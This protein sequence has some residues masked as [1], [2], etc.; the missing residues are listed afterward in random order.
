[1]KRTYQM[2]EM[3]MAEMSECILQAS[4]NVTVNSGATVNAESVGV[5]EEAWEDWDEYETSPLF[6][7]FKGRINTRGWRVASA[8]IH[9][10][11]QSSSSSNR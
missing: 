11:I 3:M 5:K 4:P 8:S 7:T 1:M 2:P 6:L 10:L 9:F